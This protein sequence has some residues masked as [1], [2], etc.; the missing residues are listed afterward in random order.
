MV[1]RILLTADEGKVLTD[2]TV[3]GK[4][5]YLAAGREASEFREITDE[6]YNNIL[7]AEAEEALD[8]L[9]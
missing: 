2:G 7:K 6:E 9:N 5:I 8:K 3:Y 1:T 4:Y